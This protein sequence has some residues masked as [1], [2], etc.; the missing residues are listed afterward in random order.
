MPALF[1][2]AFA[3]ALRDLHADLRPDEQEALRPCRL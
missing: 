3:P 2:L 1:A